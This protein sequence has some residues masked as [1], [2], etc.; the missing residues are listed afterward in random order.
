MDESENLEAT[1]SAE[2]LPENA[3]DP[4][5]R[6]RAI[7]SLTLGAILGS[8]LVIASRSRK[9]PSIPGGV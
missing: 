5:E 9:G 2:D 8:C 4:T 3:V 7:R 6:E 1:D